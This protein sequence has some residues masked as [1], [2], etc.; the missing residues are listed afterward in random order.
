MRILH[1]LH[2]IDRRVQAAWMGLMVQYMR[3]NAERQANMAVAA[4]TTPAQLFHVLRR[5]V[6]SPSRLCQQLCCTQCASASAASAHAS[7][8]VA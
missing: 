6:S 5:Q 7:V 8:G 4:P 2:L 3:R 1:G